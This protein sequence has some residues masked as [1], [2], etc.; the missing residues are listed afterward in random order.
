M[1]AMNT[2]GL[3]LKLQRIRLDVKAKDLARAAGKHPAWVSRIEA[4]RIVPAHI[5]QDY[6]AALAT[7][8]TSATLAEAVA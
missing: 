7:L 3:D 1:D 5:A 4:R 6:L 2:T 8:A